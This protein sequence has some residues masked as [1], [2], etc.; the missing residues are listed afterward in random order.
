MVNASK[1]REHMQVFGSCGNRIGTVDR[2][3]GDFLKLT[4]S[5]PEAGGQHHFF[6]L[7]WVESV[8]QDVRLNRFCDQVKRDWQTRPERK[9]ETADLVG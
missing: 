2:V 3:E 7:D 4:K 8:G 6:P 9:P 1:I 5:D